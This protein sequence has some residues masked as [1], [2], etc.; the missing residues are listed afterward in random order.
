MLSRSTADYYTH[1]QGDIVSNV[2]HDS[3]SS[4][5]VMLTADSGGSTGAIVQ[6]FGDDANIQLTLKAQGTGSVVIGNS[7]NAV[8]I[9]QTF[10]VQFTPGVLNASTSVQSTIT[11]TG[12]TAGRPLVFTPTTPGLSMA[13]AFRAQCSTANELRFTQQNISAST[14]GTGESTARGILIQL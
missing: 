11:V 7:S 6:A 8:Q 13:Y 2:Q 4:H 12:L 9:G 10:T 3:P 1:F 5:G 14:I